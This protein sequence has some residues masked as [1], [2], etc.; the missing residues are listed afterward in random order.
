MSVEFKSGLKMK[1][2]LRNLKIMIIEAEVCGPGPKSIQ[3]FTKKY[4]KILWSKCNSCQNSA[5][6]APYGPDTYLWYFR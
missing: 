1:P 4:H 5:W 6:N 2:F 3:N